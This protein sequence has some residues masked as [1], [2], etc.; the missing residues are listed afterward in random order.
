V[1]YAKMY[2]RNAPYDWIKALLKF[3][4]D[5]YGMGQEKGLKSKTPQN[6]LVSTGNNRIGE[7]CSRRDLNPSRSLERAS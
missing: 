6:T 4:V 1:Q 7:V 2:H 5:T 3:H